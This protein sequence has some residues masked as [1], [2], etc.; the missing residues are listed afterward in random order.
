MPSLNTYS[1]Q[2]ILV[3]KNLTYTVKEILEQLNLEGFNYCRDTIEKFLIKFNKFESLINQKPPGR[4]H[5][6]TYN[7]ELQ[8]IELLKE[9]DEITLTELKATI[10]KNIS[11]STISR[12][13]NRHNYKSKFTRY[14]QFVSEKNQ[15][16]RFA[17]SLLSCYF[18]DNFNNMIFTDETTVKIEVFA[19]R[20]WASK[21][22]KKKWGKFK[23]PISVICFE[24]D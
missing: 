11:N 9:D 1:K 8:L 12:I 17:Y 15:H 6:L 10:G 3:L 21:Y 23:H 24:F 13:I 7:E 18:G 19:T 5:I 22:D 20:K 14:C 2:R 16:K 4:R